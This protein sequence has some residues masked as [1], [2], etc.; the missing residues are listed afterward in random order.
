VDDDTYTSRGKNL[1]LG[2]SPW[3]D[4]AL[5]EVAAMSQAGPVVGFSPLG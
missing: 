3:A 4:A 5:R 1:V 2:I